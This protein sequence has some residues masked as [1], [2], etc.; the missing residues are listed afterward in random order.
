MV[1]IDY[2]GRCKHGTSKAL[3]G[4]CIAC[5]IM[6]MHFFGAHHLYIDMTIKHRH[7]S[8]MNGNILW[9]EV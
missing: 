4:L 2:F 7:G 8:G 1:L 6:R 3:R 5:G 9:A